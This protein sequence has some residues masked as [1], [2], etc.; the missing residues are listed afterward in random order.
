MCSKQTPS[1]LELEV[2]RQ[3]SG[4]LYALQCRLFAV[5]VSVHLQTDCQNPLHAHIALVHCT[6]VGTAW[7]AKQ[8]LLRPV[9]KEEISTS[10][11]RRML[12]QHLC[13]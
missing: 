12:L 3:S 11:L 9:K 7:L 6:P 13:C 1:R 4:A 2:W 5:F 8:D 10:E